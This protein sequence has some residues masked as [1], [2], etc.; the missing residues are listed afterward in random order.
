ME[1]PREWMNSTNANAVSSSGMM[2]K[3]PCADFIAV[4][5]LYLPDLGGWPLPLPRPLPPGAGRG[6]LYDIVETVGSE[7]SQVVLNGDGYRS[8]PM[9]L[10]ALT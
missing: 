10:A 7:G 9:S 3:T 8:P 2:G 1:E 4:P 5:P 6:K